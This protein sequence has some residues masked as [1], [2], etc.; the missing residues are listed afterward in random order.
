MTSQYQYN[1]VNGMELPPSPSQRPRHGRTLRMLADARDRVLSLAER[2]Q[3]QVKMAKARR[4]AV[5]CSA[6]GP[7]ITY[8]N[9]LLIASKKRWGLAFSGSKNLTAPG[10]N[11][12]PVKVR[13]IT[14]Y[15]PD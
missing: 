9:W 10:A 5:E 12:T 2:D 1:S 11:G 3:R 8:R 14:S 6:S 13:S 15:R 7:S 4:V